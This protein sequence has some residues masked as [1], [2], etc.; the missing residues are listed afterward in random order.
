MVRKT[1]IRGEPPYPPRAKCYLHRPPPEPERVGSEGTVTLSICGDSGQ[2]AGEDCPRVLTR[3]FD[4]DLAPTETCT[5][6]Q[7]A[8]EVPPAEGADGG[9]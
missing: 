5:L 7:R 2:I 9:L 3:T 6:H 8:R 4:A 1:Y